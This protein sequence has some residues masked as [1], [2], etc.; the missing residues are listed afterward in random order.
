MKGLFMAN[1]KI[2]LIEDDPAIRRAVELCLKKE[3]MLVTSVTNGIDA[4]QIVQDTSFD[5]ILLDLMIP[6]IDGFELISRI[7]NLNIYTPLLII[8]GKEEEHNKILAL[9]LG[10][11]DYLTKPFSFHLL[12][13]KVKAFVRRMNQYAQTTNNTAVT[14]G[15]FRFQPDTMRFYKNEI[16]VEL[17]SKE[18]KL[19]MVFIQNPNRVFTKEQLYQMVWNETVVD[20]NTIMVYIKRLRQKLEDD[21]KSP[22]YIKTVWGIGYQFLTEEKA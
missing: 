16:P 2:L 21:A 9:G 10:A 8:S 7:R 19:L 11:D 12:I 5:L 17:T 20:D 14:I 18:L 13:S 3:M 4:L 1:E 6:G 22:K 15:P